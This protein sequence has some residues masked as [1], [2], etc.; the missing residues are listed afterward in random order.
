M[1]LRVQ[2][3][4]MLYIAGQGPTAGDGSIV[5]AGDIEAQV[6]QVFANIQAL[7]EAAG[8]TFN[9]VVFMNMYV[10]DIRFRE[11]ITM[12]RN[13]ILEAPFPAATMVQIGSLA[14]TDWLVEID[15][16]AALD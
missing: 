14:S 9:N 15:A 3:N 5:G 11:T 6:R 8:A 10:T 12:V 4:E 2:A 16:I 7:L 1:A 13:E